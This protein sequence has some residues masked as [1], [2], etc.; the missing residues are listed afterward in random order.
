MFTQEI[1]N[2]YMFLLICYHLVLFGNLIEDYEMLTYLGTSLATSCALM[3][4]INL[5][6]TMLVNFSQLRQKCRYFF[7]K[8][9]RA[10]NIKEY[11]KAKLE[12]KAFD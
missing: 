1:M 3:L 2:E 9:L 11:R 4:A 7:L 6:I 10:K 12:Q 8:R 5:L